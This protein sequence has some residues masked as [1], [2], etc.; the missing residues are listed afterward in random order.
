MT[1]LS[2]KRTLS[3]QD[4]ELLAQAAIL[5]AMEN[6]WNEAAKINERIL[7]TNK[8]NVEALNRLA[9]AFKRLGEQQKAEKTYRRV[10][11]IDPHNIIARK[12]LEKISKSNGN[13]YT[14]GQSTNVNL[15][16]IFIYE[17]GKTK[18]IN[19]INLAPPTILA[20]LNCGDELEMNLKKH[21]VAISSQDGIYLGALPDD[22]AHRLITFISFGNKYKTYVKSATPKILTVLI[23]EIERSPKFANQPSFQN[24]F[25]PLED[26]NSSES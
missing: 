21:S 26:R 7:E 5:T 24:N 10:V 22:L 3:P 17:P 19:L 1:S 8:D 9:Q 16:Q 20:T 2:P 13:G 15:S 25:N 4:V 18:L 14:N 23:K 12:N 11:E 6:R